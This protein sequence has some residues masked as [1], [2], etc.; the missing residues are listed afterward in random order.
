ML[1]KGFAQARSAL[2]EHFPSARAG[3]GSVLGDM[4]RIATS[5]GTLSKGRQAFRDPIEG[6]AAAMSRSLLK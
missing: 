3:I 5:L 1:P 6:L 4:E 2:V